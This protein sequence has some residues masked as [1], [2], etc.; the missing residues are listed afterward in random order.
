MRN[1]PSNTSG[2]QQHYDHSSEGY[3]GQI[4]N[5]VIGFAPALWVLSHLNSQLNGNDGAAVA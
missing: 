3:G 2:D 1:Q 4:H 5:V